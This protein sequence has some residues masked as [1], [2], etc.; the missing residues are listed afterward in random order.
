MRAYLIVTG[1]VFGLITLAHVARLFAEGFGPAKEPAFVL[2]TII[3]A[4]LSF[5]AFRLLP[6]APRS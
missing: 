6:R 3:A 2:L 4:A 5:W 1:I